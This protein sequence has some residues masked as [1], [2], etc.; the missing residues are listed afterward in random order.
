MHSFSHFLFTAAYVDKGHHS[1]QQL[2]SL[3]P[4]DKYNRFQ[5]VDRRSI[6]SITP[7][8][9]YL[10]LNEVPNGRLISEHGSKERAFLASCSFSFSFFFSRSQYSTLYDVKESVLFILRTSLRSRKFTAWSSLGTL[11]DPRDMRKFK[12]N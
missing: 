5:P 10:A 7:F 6:F 3:P 2:S 4:L 9:I 1:H 11:E 8:Q 12:G